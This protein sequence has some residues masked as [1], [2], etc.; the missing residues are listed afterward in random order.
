MWCDQKDLGEK[1]LP[2]QPVIMKAKF[3]S[4]RA[5]KKTMGVGGAC[6]EGNGNSL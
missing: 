1:K 6:R 3:Y 2:K 5:E 4:R